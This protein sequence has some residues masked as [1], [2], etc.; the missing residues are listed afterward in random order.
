MPGRRVATTR[1]QPTIVRSARW[2]SL[3]ALLLLAGLV[4][5][6]A[7]GEDSIY[8]IWRKGHELEA[9]QAQVD[10]LQAENDSLRQVL[11]KLEN[12]MD[13]VEKVAREEYG[14]SKPGERIYRLRPSGPAPAGR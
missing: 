10:R 7:G 6:F 4:Y 3:L 14:M 12:D 13:F 8:R 5:A 1:R 9:L 2:R 11:W